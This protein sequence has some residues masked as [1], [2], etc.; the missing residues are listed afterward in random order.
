MSGVEMECSC[1]GCGASF[2]A[3]PAG[4]HRL[5][6]G[7]GPTA[8]AVDAALAGVKPHLMVTDPP[9]RGRI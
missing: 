5:V 9:Y 4:G 3:A 1:V 6:C 8:E 2:S 7:D